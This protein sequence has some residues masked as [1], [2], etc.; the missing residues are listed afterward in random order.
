MNVIEGSLTAPKGRFALVAA[1]RHKLRGCVG[2]DGPEV[3]NLHGIFRKNSAS[4]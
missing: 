4:P 3:V 2:R 1:M